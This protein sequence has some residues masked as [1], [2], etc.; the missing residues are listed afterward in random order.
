MNKLSLI[1]G[2]QVST[3]AIVMLIFLML[4]GI[5]FTVLVGNV[6]SENDAP[7]IMRIIFYIFMSMWI[8]TALFMLIYHVSN[9]NSIK[10]VSLFDINTNADS[11]DQNSNDSPLQKLRDL[12][13]LKIEGLIN[14]E[15]YEKKR[16]QIMG[17]KW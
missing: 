5:G 6:L 14:Q 16:A 3:A 7:S 2:K 8:G 9:L 11:N 12:E 4:F 17:D 10:G 13:T 15:E 1:P